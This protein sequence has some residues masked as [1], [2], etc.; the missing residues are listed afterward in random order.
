MR[1]VILLTTIILTFANSFLS[2]NPTWL[3]SNYFRANNQEVISTLT[4]NN[5]LPNFTFI[6][7]SPCNGTPSL[8]YGIKNYRGTLII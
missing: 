5:V 7:S 3:T 6:Y 2:S 4:G 8:G 1:F